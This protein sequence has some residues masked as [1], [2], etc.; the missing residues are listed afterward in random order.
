MYLSKYGSPIKARPWHKDAVKMAR[1]GMGAT[2]IA[3]I[4][5]GRKSQESTV[6]DFLSKLDEKH[7]VPVFDKLKVL[8]WDIET[9]PNVSAHWGMWQQNI[10]KGATVRNAG[11]LSHA[12]S[13]GNSEE[14][15]V[16]V[17]SP[18]DA[19][20]GNHEM[21][22]REAWSLLDNADVV[23][24]HNCL[25]ESHKVLTKNLDWVAIRDLNIGDELIG[26]DEGK[27]P[28]TNFRDSEGKWAGQGSNR[29][30]KVCKITDHKTIKK[31]AF[32]VTLSDGSEVITTADHYWLGKTSQTGVLTWIKTE[33]LIRRKA[34]IV[35]YMN[36]WDKD[37]SYNAGWL[38]GFFDGE[39]SLS[40]SKGTALSGMQVCQRPTSA[41]KRCLSILDSYNIDYSAP[42]VKVGGVGRGD[43]EYIYTNGK[44]DTLEFIG[45][46]DVV[47]FKEQLDYDKLGTLTSVGRPT[48]T[49]MSVE[50]VGIKN[51]VVLGTDS[52]TYFSEGFAMHNCKNFDIRKMNSE[53][54]KLGLPP[55]SPYKVY[56]TLRV[57][58]RHFK[59]E[60]NDLDS[61][62]EI[63][64]VPY[65]KVKHEGMPLWMNCIM[66]DQDAL[67][68]MAEYN[69]GD[70]PTLRAVFKKL[71]PWDNQGI[72]FALMGE[73]MNGCPYCG[74]DSLE[75]TTKFVYTSAR[76]YP[77]YRCTS[78]GAN[79]R[80]VHGS[81]GV[82]FS[83]VA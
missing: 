46:F 29:Y 44:W 7:L 20:N 26:F 11:L 75:Q 21:I 30:M 40:Y 81:G 45:K 65:R 25:E 37:N 59:F 22:V 15:H 78:C 55:P 16:T 49:V 4:L 5:L 42:K 17:L 31:E 24:G 83:R 12:W 39:G 6:R 73:E 54:I 28:F 2:E 41:W 61:L 72:N 35:K 9:S 23:V 33:D 50:P 67:N 68:R 60:R 52:S 14:V 82:M 1:Q 56:D 63:L 71:L 69:K 19:Y 66:G 79:S 34:H 27:S 58:K 3:E 57:A 62:C 51:I 70:I 53:F 18:E 77:L 13:W 80:A 48:L 74:E 64:K 36:V 76:K 38:S 43:C 10:N 47:K 8:F 32:K